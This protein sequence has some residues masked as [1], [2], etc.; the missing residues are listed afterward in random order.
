MK[1]HWDN[2]WKQIEDV[3]H[4]F[5]QVLSNAGL[6]GSTIKKFAAFVKGWNKLKDMAEDFD[7]FITPVESIVNTLPWE[8]PCFAEKWKFWKDYLQEQHG[9]VMRSRSEKMALAYLE[10]LSESSEE[11]ACKIIDFSCCLRAK[12]FILP[13]AKKEDNN[14]LINIQSDGTGTFG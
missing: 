10:Q 1:Q 14:N 7:Q 8:T 13:P 6:S 11:K 2:I 5:E 4:E 3:N 9:Q 12:N